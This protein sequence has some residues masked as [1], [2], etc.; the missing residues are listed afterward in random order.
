MVKLT[1]FGYYGY[2]NAG[3]EAVLAGILHGLRACGWRIVAPQPT[4]APPHSASK[5][6]PTPPRSSDIVDVARGR[7]LEV[8]VISGD[9]VATRQLHGVRAVARADWRQLWAE[10]GNA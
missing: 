6:Q 3:D 8:T 10:A 2:G 5:P 9:P 7:R 1:L 4:P